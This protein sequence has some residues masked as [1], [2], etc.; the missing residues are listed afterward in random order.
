MKYGTEN[1]VMTEKN[2]FAYK[3]FLLLNI[4]GFIFYVKFATPSPEK[5]Y[6]ISQ[7]PVLSSLPFLKI[8]LETQPPSLQKG[9][10][11]HIMLREISHPFTYLIIESPVIKTSFFTVQLF[12]NSFNQVTTLLSLYTVVSSFFL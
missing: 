7:Q 11:V 10:G 12:A 6:P 1:S 3:L 2:V 4:S 9:R 8:W 5:S